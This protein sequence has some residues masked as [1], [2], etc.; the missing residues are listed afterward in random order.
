[1]VFLRYLVTQTTC[2]YKRET[3]CRPRLSILQT[4]CYTFYMKA[5]FRYRI[6]PKP[7][8]REMLART[9][10]CVRVVWNDALALN[11]QQY[12]QHGE[13]V[14]NSDLQKICITQAKRTE[15]R[16]WLS[17]VSNAALQQSVR[18]L[19]QAFSNFFRACKGQGLAQ[20]PR[21]KSRRNQQSFRLTK[22]CFSVHSNSV[23]LQKIGHVRMKVSRPLPSLPSSVTVIKDACNRYFASF[24]VEL[25]DGTLPESLNGVGIDV[26]LETYATLSTGEKVDN[27]RWLRHELPRLRRLQKSLSRKKKGSNNWHKQRL[28]VAKLH[29]RV[30]DARTDFTHKLSTRLVR[31]NQAIAVEDLCL[32]GLVRTRLAKSF[33]DAGLGQLVAMI[34]AKCARY[35]RHFVKIDRFF[36]SSQICSNC[37]HRDGPKHQSIRKWQCP[38]CGAS[39]DRDVN[40]AI[41]IKVAGGLSE[42]QNACG[43]SVS[44]EVGRAVL[45]EARTAP[46]LELKQLSLI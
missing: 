32:K 45:G 39:H 33:S 16:K 20:F 36:P 10:G 29:A 7:L 34:E 26:G 18:D 35:D 38:N 22:Q 43:E 46:K 1:M 19:G 14:K 30:K 15:E 37:G 23:K 17:E 21:F 41:N 2:A 4:Y 11:N 24:V 42:T 5:R 8:Q 6:Y 44:P 12:E 3:L 13:S 28:K 31:E 27:P 25:P 9:F 40:A